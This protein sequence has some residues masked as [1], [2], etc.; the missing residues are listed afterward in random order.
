M[1]HIVCYDISEDKTRRLV[2][3]RLLDFGVR[4]QE[5]VFEALLDDELYAR[6]MMAID[7]A[8]LAK[9]D[10]VRVYKVCARCVE[11]VKIY[12]P[13]EVSHDPDFYVI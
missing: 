1:L 8:P 12:G 7:K 6:M 11:A 5:S 4:I 2:S 13:G 10:K 3:E 9:S